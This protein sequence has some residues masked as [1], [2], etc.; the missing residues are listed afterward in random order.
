MNRPDKKAS[1]FGSF[2]Y[3]EWIVPIFDY[4]RSLR[5]GEIVFEVVLPVVIAVL[6]TATY[7]RADKL[8]VALNCLLHNKNTKSCR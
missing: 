6:C 1:G 3:M 5:K 2:I 4:Y 8:F 7:Y